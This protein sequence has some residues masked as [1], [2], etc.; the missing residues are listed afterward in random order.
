MIKLL[1][2]PRIAVVLF[3]C[4]LTACQTQLPGPRRF[5]PAIPPSALS[6]NNID[7]TGITNTVDATLLQPPSQPFTLGPGDKIEVEILNDLSSRALL[8]VT[9]D[10]KIYFNMLQGVDVWGL[11]LA[12]TQE[13]LQKELQRYNRGKI[14]VGITLRAVE[15]KK[16][17]LLGRVTA[18]GVYAMTNSLTLLEAIYNGGGPLN[19]LGATGAG[20]TRDIATIGMN[21]DLV[22]YKKSF[23]LRKG[24]M[25]PVDFVRLSKG[26][27]RQNI[28]LQPDD[29]VYLAPGY[30]QEVHVIGAVGAPGTI[31]FTQGMTLISVIATAGGTFPGSYT[32]QVAIVRGSLQAPEIALVDLKRIEKGLAPNVYVA[33][34]DI[35]YVPITPY[36]KLK[37]YWDVMTQTF[38]GSVAINEGSRAVL[39]GPPP[40]NGILIPFGS[41]ISVVPPSPR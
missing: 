17:W 11:T 34:G 25:L 35:I 16:V 15:S 30:S 40:V 7:M 32:R 31:P 27:M 10:G 13:L 36:H 23:V 9:P 4:F 39:N 38:V 37:E 12:Q 2:I 20:G 33:P 26:D 5:N 6:T 22:D 28:Y 41:T 19:L 14:E 8:T 29:Y 1:T 21:E 3:A 24:K 18:P